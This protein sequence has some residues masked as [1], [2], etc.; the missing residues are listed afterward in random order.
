MKITVLT[1]EDNKTPIQTM[2]TSLSDGSGAPHECKFYVSYD[3]FIAGFPRDG[4]RAVI[5]ARRG[6]DGMESARAAKLLC[7]ETPL[8]WFSDDNGFGTESFRIGC[9][10]FTAEPIGQEKLK[11]ILERI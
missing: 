8:L 3:D 9:R 2:L 1:H 11:T 7:P 6:A 4:S 5:I 10:Y